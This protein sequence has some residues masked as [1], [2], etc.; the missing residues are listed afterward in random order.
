MTPRDRIRRYS[1]VG[2]VAAALVW[3]L[4]CFLILLSPRLRALDNLRQQA[5]ASTAELNGMKKEIEDAKIIGGPAPGG[6]R[7]DKFGI[8]STDEEQLFL[9]DLIAFCSDTANVLNI[10]RRSEFAQSASPTP[11]P[12]QPAQPGQA[13][14][15][16]AP[17]NPNQPPQP[18]ILRVP[19]TVS[20]SGTFLSSFYLLRKLES[21][22]RLLTV[23][24]MD[25]ATD[26]QHGYPRI[27]GNI[28]IELYLVKQPAAA[29]AVQ[30][31]QPAGTG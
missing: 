28:T 8:L 6:A 1:R 3:A 26:G 9:S 24:R 22:Q 29:P 19:H 21:Y 25:L 17:A 27:N 18:V 10:V 2:G 16:Q 31:G 14:Q 4:L 13:G 30:V 20:F 12:G 23:E 15:P 7:F 11:T 5:D